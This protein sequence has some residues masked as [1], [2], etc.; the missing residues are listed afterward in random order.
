MKSRCSNVKKLAYA[1][2]GGRGIYVCEDWQQFIPFM[3]WALT[4]GYKDT[5]ECDRIDNDGPYS[6]ENC[7]WVTRE[8]NRKNKRPMKKIGMR[9]TLKEIECACRNAG[10]DPVEFAA[11]LPTKSSRGYR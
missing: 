7:R 5:L 4:N 11:C 6:P 2:Y 3:Q 9:Y 10:I 1:D 8:E